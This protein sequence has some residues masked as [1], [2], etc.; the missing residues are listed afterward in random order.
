MPDTSTV[1][2]TKNGAYLRGFLTVATAMLTF[3]AAYP[4]LNEAVKDPMFWV[5]E[6]AV[7]VA[8]WRVWLD[9]SSNALS[10]RTDSE[11][12]TNQTP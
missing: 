11:P 12:P 2:M 8:A 1:L 5:K 9:Q 3:A 10:P 6:L 4:G 7:G